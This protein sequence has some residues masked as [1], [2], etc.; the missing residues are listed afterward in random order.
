MLTV[1]PT[2]ANAPHP[3]QH[4]KAPVSKT[5]F[6]LLQHRLCILRG[7]PSHLPLGIR[8]PR[9]PSSGEA[10]GGDGAQSGGLGV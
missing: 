8:E 3:D 4:S 10:R 2:A 5:L 7:N 6:L 1:P 9:T